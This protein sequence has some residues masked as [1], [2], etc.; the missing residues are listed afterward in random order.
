LKTQKVEIGLFQ[1]IHFKQADKEK[2]E[3]EYQ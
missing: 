1:E 3:K 2:W